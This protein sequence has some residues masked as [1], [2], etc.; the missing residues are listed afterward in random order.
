MVQLYTAHLPACLSNGPEDENVA[1]DDDEQGEEE[2]KA[3]EQHGVGTHP[4]CEGHVVPGAGCQ[5]PLGHVGTWEA[6]RQVLSR[7]CGLAEAN[8]L[9]RGFKCGAWG[10]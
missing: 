2:D 6:E 1:E 3:E 10:S 7:H 5:Q 9:R 4:G 8:L